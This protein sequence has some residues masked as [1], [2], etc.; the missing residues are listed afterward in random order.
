MSHTPLT[1]GALARICQGDHVQEP[2]VLQVLARQVITGDDGEVLTYRFMLNDGEYRHDGGLLL[3]TNKLKRLWVPLANEDKFFQQ[4]TVIKVKKYECKRTQTELNLCVVRLLDLEVLQMGEVVGNMF[5]NPLT[6]AR[7]GKVPQGD[8]FSFKDKDTPQV[9]IQNHYERQS[10]KHQFQLYLIDCTLA[11][12]E[13]QYLNGAFRNKCFPISGSSVSP[14]W[15][16][17]Y[18]G[19]LIEARAA[20]ANGE[21]PNSRSPEKWTIQWSADGG[22]GDGPANAT[23]LILAAMAG[24]NAIVKLLLEQPGLNPNCYVFAYL[25]NLP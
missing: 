22:V 15:K 4:Y 21:D 12:L 18:K 19:K 17:C 8:L 24:H 6:I 20:L 25:L 3:A 14:L 9:S 5:G 16:L 23:V 10:I 7:D 2:V 11:A 1:I 13:K